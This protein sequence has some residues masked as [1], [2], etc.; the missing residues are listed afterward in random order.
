M[1]EIGM[2]C[3][4]KI[5]I[6]VVSHGQAGLID[7]LL[8]DVESSCQTASLE[9]ILTLNLDE[10][11]P[12]ALDSFS[13]PV[14]AIRNLT[15][16]GFAANH[17]QAF[18]YAT[19][20]YFCV[21]N[22]DIRLTTDPFQA[23]LECLKDPVVGVV[24]PLVVG[25]DGEIEDSARHFPTPFKIL[26]KLFGGCKGSDYLIGGELLHPD[27]VGGMFMLFQHDIFASIGGFNQ[28]YFLYYEDV[29]LCAR[30]RLSGYEVALCPAVRVIHHAHR[31][32]HHSFRF[33][34][35]HLTSMARFFFSPVY[36]RV[37][38]RKWL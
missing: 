25:D 26:C 24:A 1:E 34:R 13:F 6:S 19:G 10:T 9:F 2:D 29:D 11:L 12:F 27:W 31:S 8:R 7:N 32:S 33:L 37:Q 30:L 35:W 3:T 20:E 23:L 18:T 4:T 38:C 14:K 28:R 21:L 5:S 22:P 17:N 36:W 15:P 16:M